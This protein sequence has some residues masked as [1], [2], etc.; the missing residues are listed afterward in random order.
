MF[1]LV[2]QDVFLFNDSIANNIS[3]GKQYVNLNKVV[4]ASKANAHKFISMLENKYDTQIKNHGK[5]LFC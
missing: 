2:S 1:G 5:P 3:L 4:D